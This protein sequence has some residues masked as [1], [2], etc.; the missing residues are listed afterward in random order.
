MFFDVEHNNGPHTE[1]KDQN[2]FF[3]LHKLLAVDFNLTR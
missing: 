2:A 1:V 3:L